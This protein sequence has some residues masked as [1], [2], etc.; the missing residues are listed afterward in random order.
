MG[1]SA[2]IFVLIVATPPPFRARCLQFTLS[3]VPS[4]TVPALSCSVAVSNLSDSPVL[5]AGGFNKLWLRVAY[6]TNGIWHYTRVW[7]PGGG[8]GVLPPHT[9]IKDT[10][11]VPLGATAVKLGLPITSLTWRG[12]FAW[13]VVG[14]CPEALYPVARLFM[15]PDERRRSRTEW[16][17]EY[18]V[19]GDGRQ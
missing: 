18:S 1:V 14:H 13:Y 4:N 19:Q 3:Q 9:E 12:R 10:V 6:S 8:N 2:A 5:Y 7:T 15:A 16:S 17:R 11:E